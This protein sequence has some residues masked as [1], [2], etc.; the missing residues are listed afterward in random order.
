MVDACAFHPR[1]K[2][3]HFLTRD[4]ELFT[5]FYYIFSFIFTLKSW[6]DRIY[7][8]TWKVQHF[9][10]LHS[11]AVCVFFF[12]RPLV[13]NTGYNLHCFVYWKIETNIE[14][15]DLFF[16]YIFCHNRKR[17]PNTWP[18]AEFFPCWRS[19]IFFFVTDA[20]FFCSL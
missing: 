18:P 17:M 7:R 10:C 6:K 2:Y 12:S 13:Q 19:Y 8:S 1:E 16:L 20:R 14:F 3:P 9:T 15:F 5:F 4:M 11:S